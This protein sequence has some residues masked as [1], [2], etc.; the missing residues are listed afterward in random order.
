MNNRPQISKGFTIIEV[1]I[2]LLIVTIILGYTVAL[3]PVQQELKQYRQ[4][5][6]EMDQ[7]IEAIYA[8]AQV[9]GRL[10]CADSFAAPDGRA[11]QDTGADCTANVGWSGLVPAITLGISGNHDNNG[12]LVDPW[13]MP[14]RYQVT[15]DDRGVVGPDP[16]NLGVAG[17]DFVMPNDIQ[18]VGMNLLRPDLQICTV[19]PSLLATDT[20]CGGANFTVA[21]GTGANDRGTP[22]VVLSLGKDRG[23]DNSVVEIE[24]I[25]N[26]LDGATDIVFVNTTRNEAAATAYDDIVKWISPNTLYSRMIDAG[27]LP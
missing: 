22:A 2:V 27:Q 17:G 12:S 19:N 14:Y 3:F 6:D 18:N 1:A 11:D 20:D 25:D 4:A 26:T 7:I 5:N 24:N 10:P 9:N 15:S 16:A 8:Y 13:G 23:L 21:G